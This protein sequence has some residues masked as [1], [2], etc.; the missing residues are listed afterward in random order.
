VL[1]YI[2]DE[3]PGA[4]TLARVWTKVDDARV[5]A[6]MSRE[7]PRSSASPPHRSD[8]RDRVSGP[9]LLPTDVRRAA[10]FP[11]YVPD[12]PGLGSAMSRRASS[13]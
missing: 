5:H 4:G 2:A 11:V 10:Q 7:P 8:S 6:R 9:Y 12:L 3:I 13:A 1:H